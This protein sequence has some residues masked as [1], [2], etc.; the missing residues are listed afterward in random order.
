MI[1]ITKSRKLVWWEIRV[2]LAYL[3]AHL[4][5]FNGQQ[6]GIV[7]KMTIDE[8][9]SKDEEDGDCYKSYGA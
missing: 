2:V 6:P 5:Y 4:I 8:R 1:E 7:Q 3:A 9:R